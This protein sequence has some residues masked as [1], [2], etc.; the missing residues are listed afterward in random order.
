M[1]CKQK[2]TRDKPIFTATHRS[3]FRLVLQT[4]EIFIL[5]TLR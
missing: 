3:G 4:I 1:I 5:S 2:L